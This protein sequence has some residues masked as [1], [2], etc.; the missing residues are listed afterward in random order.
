MMGPCWAVN[1]SRK[2]ATF[3]VI[4]DEDVEAVA[5]EKRKVEPPKNLTP[6]EQAKI[7]ESK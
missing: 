3:V 2:N 4:E 5:G 1:P 7:A 6:E